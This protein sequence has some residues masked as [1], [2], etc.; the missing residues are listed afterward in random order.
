[1]IIKCSTSVETDVF[2]IFNKSNLRAAIQHCDFWVSLAVSISCVIIALCSNLW[3]YLSKYYELS[4]MLIQI[5]AQMLGLILAVIAIA[6]GVFS[7]NLV[8]KIKQTGNNIHVSLALFL[9]WFLYTELIAVIVLLM[10]CCLAQFVVNP[11]IGETILYKILCYCWI[12]ISSFIY[13][14]SVLIIFSII[15]LLLYLFKVRID[16]NP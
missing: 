15:E 16:L 13:V 12:F 11:I 8:A 6:Y 2:T 9:G 1:M 10:N 4:Q 3:I 7:E 14:Y 5:P